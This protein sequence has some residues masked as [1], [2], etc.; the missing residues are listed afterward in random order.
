MYTCIQGGGG[1]FEKDTLTCA[2]MTKHQNILLHFSLEN[3][4]YV[5]GFIDF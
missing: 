1:K 2:I 4:K 5:R 3:L